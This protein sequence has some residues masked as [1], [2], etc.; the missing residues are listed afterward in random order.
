MT[1]V[2]FRTFTQGGYVIALFPDI[3]E[4]NGHVLSYMR[5]GQHG[6]ADY[7][8]MIKATRPATSEEIAPL[9][10]ELRGQGYDDLK[11]ITKRTKR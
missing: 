1:R 11:I 9:A 5:L 6:P 8:G 10:K 7:K 3:E 4:R 2:V